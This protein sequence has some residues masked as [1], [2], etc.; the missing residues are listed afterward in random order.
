M[1]AK[2]I[3]KNLLLVATM[4]AAGV[5]NAADYT[6]TAVQLETGDSHWYYLYNVG[7]KKF[8]CGATGKKATLKSFSE[9]TSSSLPS[10]ICVTSWTSG[11]N[12][13]YGIGVDAKAQ[14][15]N[16]MAIDGT[17]TCYWL[18][19]K[20]P[21][22]DKTNEEMTADFDTYKDDNY[23]MTFKCNN[24]EAYYGANENGEL[25]CTATTVSNNEKWIAVSIT[26]FEEALYGVS[27]EHA[28]YFQSGGNYLASPSKAGTFSTTS[29]TADAAQFVC[30]PSTNKTVACYVYDIRSGF[31][32]T[33]ADALTAASEPTAIA[34]SSFTKT[35]VEGVTPS[36]DA[37]VVAGVQYYLKSLKNNGSY[38]YYDADASAVKATTDKESATAYILLPTGTKGT[39]YREYYIQN[40]K[41]GNWLVN[42][43]T[44]KGDAYL[45]SEGTTPQAIQIWNNMKNTDAQWERFGINY[46]I[47][48]YYGNN[49][50]KQGACVNGSSNVCTYS[51][52]TDQG[53]NWCLIRTD[54]EAVVS[55]NG[56]ASNDNSDLLKKLTDAGMKASLDIKTAATGYASYVLPFDAD[57]ASDC[58]AWKVT[59]VKEGKVYGESL[60]SL[61]AGEPF[62]LK[63]EA[64][65]TYNFSGVPTVSEA[66]T[67]G[68]LTGIFAPKTW[69]GGTQDESIYLMTGGVYK[70]YT[71]SVTLKAYRAYLTLTSS[72][73]AESSATGSAKELSIVLD[74]TTAISSPAEDANTEA[75]SY[76]DAS[77]RTLSQ[78]QR[79][80]NI[81]K[82][83]DGTVKKVVR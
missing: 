50:F 75:S 25:V 13:V 9:F 33:S 2:S 78:P 66:G 70:Y 53:C 12:T 59:S 14:T 62:L 19:D 16:A 1:N 6:P 67:S 44:N 56:T 63:G 40:T 15:L 80:L 71:N 82:M 41:T 49:Y 76:F 52:N 3:F 23:A 57:I 39:Q 26:D 17:L 35:E 34:I 46:E 37:Y 18:G 60:S 4:M 65:T 24:L 61:K 32:L 20:S 79:G 83:S 8:L 43:N 30:L 74:E 58:Q 10:K 51:S 68:R 27:T 28:Y 64:S 29:S 73:T 55:L 36:S 81:V 48:S 38:M 45:W 54:N 31:Y 72:D 5:A 42:T 69:D 47:V 77:G 22:S 11:E 7:A 21:Y